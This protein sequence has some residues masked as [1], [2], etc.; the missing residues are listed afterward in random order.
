M[1]VVEVKS[2]DGKKESLGEAFRMWFD[3]GK[4]SDQI[5]CSY[6]SGS[7]SVSVIVG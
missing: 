6:G 2:G 4:L 1:A 3:V 7:V 5:S